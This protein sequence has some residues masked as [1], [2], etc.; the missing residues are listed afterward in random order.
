MPNAL[1]LTGYGINCDIETHHALQKAGFSVQNIHISEV[2]G[3]KWTQN[4]PNLLAIPGGFSFGDGSS[5]SSPAA[6]RPCRAA[7]NAA[8]G[9][10]G[11]RPC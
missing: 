9:S 1:V 2:K 7:T 8:G 5:R 11:R 3:G 4:I 6:R 10:Y